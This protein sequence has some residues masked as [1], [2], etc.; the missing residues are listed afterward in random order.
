MVHTIPLTG[1]VPLLK[2]RVV[3]GRMALGKACTLQLGSDTRMQIASVMVIA[4]TLW[5]GAG[6]H[7]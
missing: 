2:K 7:H 5:G 1:T 4:T 6:G 3:E